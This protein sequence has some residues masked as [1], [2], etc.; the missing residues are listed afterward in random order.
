MDLKEQIQ[1]K[2]YADNGDVDSMYDYGV[3]LYLETP[4]YETAL[5]YLFDAASKGYT[6]SFGDIGMILYRE[7]ND[8]VGAEKWFKK[9][10]KANC[11]I[12]PVAY[13]YGMMIYLEKGD[14]EK[15]L[16]YLYKAADENY[17]LSFG[18]I[19]SIFYR[20]KDDIETARKWF[21]KAEKVNCLLGPAA[22]DYG[23]LTHFEDGNDEKA[24]SYLYKAAEDEYKPSFGEIGSI[25]FNY[26]KDIINAQQWFEK[27]EEI[28]C[29][30]APTAYEYGK[31]YLEKGDDEKALHYF[32]LSA[33]DG[34]ELAYEE[35]GE[36]YYQRNDSKNAEIWF[37]KAEEIPF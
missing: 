9:A 32:I 16:K 23:M 4:D 24:L 34:Y 35:I 2:K 21:E 14:C 1:L 19:G 29:L 18:V 8:I 7:K 22:Y 31:L 37:K 6:L 28:N 11:I 30:L 27:A 17:E 12:P 33:N 20:E 13:E 15:A 25:L 5:R 36:I 3:F 26:K 10:E